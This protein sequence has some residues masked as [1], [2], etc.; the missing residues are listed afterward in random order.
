MPAAVTRTTS[1][2][3]GFFN[4]RGFTL[5]ESLFMMVALGVFAMLSISL[6]L[7]EPEVDSGDE[8]KHWVEKG[9]DAAVPPAAWTP[10]LAPMSTDGAD[11][12][13]TDPLLSPPEDDL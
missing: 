2:N 3:S 6:Y 1:P 9:G 5:L 13:K 7:H 12:E 4:R 10:A 11:N 8:Q